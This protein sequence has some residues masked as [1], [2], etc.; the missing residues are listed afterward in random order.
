VRPL[1]LEIQGFTS[2]RE[3]QPVDFSE[4]GLFVIT[5]PTGVGKTSILDAMALALYGAVPRMGK[6]GLSALVSHGQSEARVLLEFSASARSRAS[7]SG[8]R[9]TSGSTQL[10]AA[11]SR[12]LIGMSRRSS[13]STSKASARRSS[14]RRGSSR[15]S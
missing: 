6:S 3:H 13:G 5:G 4:L 1:R 11:A 7:W 12:T 10:A 2:F 15:A 8:A 14:C 9:V